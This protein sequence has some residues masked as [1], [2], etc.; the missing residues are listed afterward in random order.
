MQLP[1]VVCY[2]ARAHRIDA[3]NDHEAIMLSGTIDCMLPGTE[4]QARAIITVFEKE[5]LDKHPGDNIVTW[6]A[7]RARGSKV[8][9]SCCQNER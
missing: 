8:E 3:I 9:R 7:A 4:A 5:K 6:A 2:F 1:V